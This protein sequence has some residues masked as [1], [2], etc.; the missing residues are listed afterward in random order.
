MKMIFLKKQL[1]IYKKFFNKIM[2]QFLYNPENPSKAFDVY[3]NKN[4][5]NTIPI[6]YKTVEKAKLEI[7]RYKLW[8]FCQIE[9]H[10]HARVLP[11]TP[12]ERSVSAQC[13]QTGGRAVACFAQKIF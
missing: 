2:K 11:S 5:K 13:F 4:P 3:I 7:T 9:S 6:K 12:L 8:L 10:R 1:K